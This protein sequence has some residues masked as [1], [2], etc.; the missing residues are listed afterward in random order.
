M[1]LRTSWVLSGHFL[2]L[3]AVISLGDSILSLSAWSLMRLSH[4]GLMAI[5]FP[6]DTSRITSSMKTDLERTA[7]YLSACLQVTLPRRFIWPS[8]HLVI[9]LR[10]SVTSEHIRTCSSILQDTPVPDFSSKFSSSP[11]S[12]DN[13]WTRLWNGNATWRPLWHALGDCTARSGSSICTRHYSPL[14]QHPW[15]QGTTAIKD[16]WTLPSVSA[17]R[18][19]IRLSPCSTYSTT[20]FVNEHS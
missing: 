6:S 18:Q 9:T 16:I 4:L 2:W 13:T 7:V 17:H 8:S 11:G 15:P 20:D 12:P 19:G 3:N 5:L 14:T 1:R 10:N